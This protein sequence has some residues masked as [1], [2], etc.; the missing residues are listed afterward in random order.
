MTTTAGCEVGAAE[1]PAVE[2]DAGSG[3]QGAPRGARPG[4]PNVEPALGVAAALG[5]LYVIWGST[6]LALRVGLETLPPFLLAGARFVTAGA[7]LYGAL[8][9][10]GA[11]APTRR[12]WGAA[13]QTGALLLV[14]GNGFLAVAQQW[15]TSGVAAV[16]VSTMPLWVALFSAAAAHA[17]RRAGRAPGSADA[18]APPTR[19][20]WAGLLVGF[21][22]AG[23]L[24]LGGQLHAAHPAG[25]V[26]LLAPVS[27]ALGSIRS[28]SLPLPRGPMATAAQMLAGGAA[29][30]ALSPALGER[31]HGMP[32]A[33][34]L[35]ALGYLIVFG[36]IVG[37][38]AF[39]Y[40]IRT[41]RPSIA[42]SYAYVN[43]LIAIALGVWLAGE[44]ASALTWAAAGI[45][46]AGVVILSS[47]G[48]PAP[49]RRSPA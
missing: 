18:A 15:V 44:Q 49:P 47:R 41:T 4:A 14:G 46:V 40:L 9:L 10:R 28:R 37:F 29:M 7:V 3:A 11:P 23:L 5:A 30:L 6:Y 20:E 26:V 2:R 27:W 1:G 17:A 42:T 48:A 36:S 45:V 43:P 33:R 22:G 21:A 38:S 39:G 24:H 19:R 12:E 35:A 32:S 31:L 16:V 8:R 25:L 13:A 34:S